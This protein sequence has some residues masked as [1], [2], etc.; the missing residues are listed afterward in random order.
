MKKEELQ[1]YIKETTKK[2]KTYLDL[3]DWRINISFDNRNDEE[4][5]SIDV[6][7]QAKFARL[8]VNMDKF[9]EDANEDF[10]N[11]VILHELL[12]IIYRTMSNK[13]ELVS[14]RLYEIIQALLLEGEE[15][16]VHHLTNVL[17]GIEK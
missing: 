14:N 2:Y 4:T 13:Y 10:V 3:N 16:D 1:E 12:H 17:G 7:V 8:S 11:K 6:N 5:C 15:K 9:N